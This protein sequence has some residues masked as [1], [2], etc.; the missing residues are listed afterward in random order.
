MPAPVVLKTSILWTAP[1]TLPMMYAVVYLS[2]KLGQV[3]GRM[4]RAIND[5]YP[6]RV[7]YPT[8]VGVL[9]GN[10]IEAG[11]DLG[12]MAAAL[13]LY[14][15]VPGPWL[16]LGIAIVVMAL[17]VYGSYVLI[18]NVFRWLALVLLAYIGAAWLAQPDWRKALRGTHSSRR[19]ASTGNS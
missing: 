12:G 8:L 15:P 2:A 7:L 17:Q 11:A 9:L 1:V 19:F 13:N 16:C 18:R 4:F 14:V 5:Y 6:R 10:T 3:S